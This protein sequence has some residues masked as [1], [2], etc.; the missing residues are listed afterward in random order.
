M[1]AVVAPQFVSFPAAARQLGI[2][3]YKFKSL[4]KAGGVT[5]LRLPGARPV[6]LASDLDRVLSEHLHGPA[7]GLE[8]TSR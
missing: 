5:V 3:T 8:A 2:S 6:V 1:G 7:R 4:A